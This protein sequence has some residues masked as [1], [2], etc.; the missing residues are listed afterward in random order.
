MELVAI[1]LQ[2]S[3]GSPATPPPRPGH[4]LGVPRGAEEG[5]LAVRSDPVD[6]LPDVVA[7]PQA[8]QLV[9]LVQHEVRPRSLW[10][11]KAEAGEMA[12]EGRH[13]GNGRVK[14]K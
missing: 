3:G 6:D 2:P 1:M 7:E 4:D 5:A 9:P 11:T 14:R 13:E 12:G 10:C 8:Q